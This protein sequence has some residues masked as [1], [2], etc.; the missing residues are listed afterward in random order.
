M[1]AAIYRGVGRIDVE[2]V[3]KPDC[4][5][6]GV[7]VKVIAC[8][9]CGS[10]IRTYSHGHPLLKIPWTMGH[11]VAGLIEEVGSSV[12]RYQVGQRVVVNPVVGCGNCAFCVR[13]Q[14]NLCVNARFFGYDFR[15]GFAEYMEVPG[16]V[17]SKPDPI[18][19]IEDA[20]SF[21][22]AT[23]A[24]PIS[25]AL[26]AAE[27]SGVGVGDT[28]AVLGAGPI[29][30]I[31]AAVAKLRG[32]QRVFMSDVREQ[33]LQLARRFGG[34]LF[35]DASKEDVVQ[36]I[37]AAS[38]GSGV[39][40]VIVACP[41]GEAQQQALRMVRRGG[42]V[43]LFG[44]LPKEKPTIELDSNR[45]H[46][47]EIKVTGSIAATPRDFSLA[48]RLLNGG[49]LDAEGLVTECF[50]IDRIADAFKPDALNRNLRIVVHPHE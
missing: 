33:R 23:T 8:G 4:P 41:S 20:V 3:S 2:D 17:L 48:V 42:T 14:Q 10:D 22:V 27:L 49:C 43:C 12:T 37:V 29:G 19:V 1:K 47:G 34:E 11:E 28:V 36:V 18:V 21:E 32:A 40:V 13:G 24:D 45:V 6:D 7:L 15:G 25:C 46:Y 44:G 26:H 31:H 30:C 9:I 38:C 39:D 16:A 5:D 35:V 50:P